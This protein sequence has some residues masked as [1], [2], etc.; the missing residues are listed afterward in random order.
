[1]FRFALQSLALLLV[2]GSLTAGLAASPAIGI[3]TARGIFLVD[4]FR[5][6]GSATLFDGMLVETAQTPSTLQLDGGVRMHLGA[7][8]RS[9]VYRE[10]LVLEKGEGELENAAGYQIEARSLRVEPGSPSAVAR[11]A[12]AG[13]SRVQVAASAG[14]VRVTAANGTLLASL[15]PGTTLEFEPQAAGAAAPFTVTGCLQKRDGRYLLTDD[16]AKVT[17]ELR[18]PG[19]DGEV[20]HRLEVIGT[21]LTSAQPAE[22]AS[23]AIQATRVKRLSEACPSSPDT[24]GPASASGTGRAAG[25]STMSKTSKAIIAGVVVAAAGAGAAVAVSSDEEEKA[26][27]SR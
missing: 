26:P 10:R 23:N 24:T 4:S 14:P 12:F 20:G 25:T 19:L 15:E 17:L 27:I 8:S 1:M 6:S 3:A 7:V 21:D 13:T 9:R 5:V 16:T 2:L 11:V 22:G 18:G